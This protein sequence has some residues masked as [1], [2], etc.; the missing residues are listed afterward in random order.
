MRP[1]PHRRLAP[2]LLGPC[3]YYARF[4]RPGAA[5]DGWLRR[6][7][8]ALALTS[9]TLPPPAWHPPPPPPWLAR[10]AD[11]AASWLVD[12]RLDFPLTLDACLAGRRD[13]CA[14]FVQ[15]RESGNR[16]LERL[17]VHEEYLWTLQADD[18]AFLSDVLVAFGPERFAGLWEAGGSLPEAFASAFG[19]PL[20]DW[21]Y[22]WAVERFGPARERSA[23]GLGSLAVSLGAVA[24]FLALAVVIASHR[25]VGG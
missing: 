7:G 17:G 24:G 16:V 10:L 8:A 2:G 13:R 5:I 11:G 9:P 22:G 14:E 6:G 21:T 12:P 1:P 25:R 23:V 20:A 4:G 19:V 3:A 15:S 18:A